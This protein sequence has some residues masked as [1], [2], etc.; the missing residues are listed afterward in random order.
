MDSDIPI[1]MARQLNQEARKEE[2][3]IKGNPFSYNSQK[4]NKYIFKKLVFPVVTP[5]SD[6]HTSDHKYIVV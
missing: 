1:I 2:S 5:S 3:P 6:S 4:I